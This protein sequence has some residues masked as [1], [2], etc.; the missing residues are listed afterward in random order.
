MDS[1]IIKINYFINIFLI[2]ELSLLLFLNKNSNIILK[3]IIKKN[4]YQ[5]INNFYEICKQGI[6][7][8]K[9]KLK[10]IINPKISIITPIYNKEKYI[11]RYFRSIQN[12]FFDEIEIILTDDYSTDFSKE[13]IEKL[14][15][16]D[17]R[18]VLIKHKKNKG[19]LK[20]R[21]EAVLKSKG[22][23]LIFLDPD[24]LLSFYILILCYY[25]AEKNNYDIIRFNIYEGNEKINLDFIVNQIIN[26]IIYKPKLSLY[27]FYGLGKLEELDYYITNKLIKKILFIK[28]LNLIDKYYLNNFM[29]DCED[30]L[31]NFILYRF[32][33]SYYFIAKIGYYYI[34][35]EESITLANKWKFK[36][37]LKSNF[38]YLKFIFQNTKNNIVE[39][40][41]ANYIFLGIYSQHKD[42]FIQLFQEV[43]D[44]GFY[45]GVIDLYLNCKYISS[46]TKEILNNIIYI[47]KQ[48]LKSKIFFN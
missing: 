16:N 21:N 5:R 13:I 12:Q 18:I 37:R 8:N 2:L 14:S 4:E 45:K 1:K 46:K 35:N 44:F 23:Y 28:S 25:E 26:K 33:N 43:N 42:Y 47:A 34:I 32:A 11:L 36:K 3:Q 31:I 15:K 41:I 48:K 6:L 30:G 10:K 39:K 19:T 20:S 24:D 27:L 40:N 17:E 9:K 29:I 7:L 38:L 22:K